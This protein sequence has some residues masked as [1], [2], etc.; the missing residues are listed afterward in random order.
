VTLYTSPS[1]SRSVRE[2]RPGRSSVDAWRAMAHPDLVTIENNLQGSEVPW[3]AIA[4]HAQ[5][6]AEKYLK[7]A[8]IARG[9]RPARTHKLVELFDHLVS[10]DASVPDLHAECELLTPF[11]SEARY[12]DKDEKEEEL[13]KLVD[14]ETGERAVAAMRLI[15]A[16]VG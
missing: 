10:L 3:T 14:A 15:I 7:A 2:R 13:P 4:Y 6:A 11:A 16:A 12:P 8:I 1:P 5:Q 9:V